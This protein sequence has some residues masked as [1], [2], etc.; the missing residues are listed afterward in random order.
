MKSKIYRYNYND[1]DYYAEGY[2]EDNIRQ[3]M[4]VYLQL[5]KD[6]LS[7]GISPNF[8]KELLLI[9]D[10]K[11]TTHYL[12]LN[13]RQTTS[14]DDLKLYKR[15]QSCLYELS[16]LLKESVDFLEYSYHRYILSNKNDDVVFMNSR[17][18]KD[19]ESQI[20]HIICY[21]YKGS[22]DLNMTNSIYRFKNLADAYKHVRFNLI[23]LGL[24]SMKYKKSELTNLEMCDSFIAGFG[25]ADG[26][27][28]N[29]INDSEVEILCRDEPVLHDLNDFKIKD[30]E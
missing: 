17:Y 2:D 29:K 6:T 24:D 5:D 27:V 21:S 4:E 13:K 23:D 3:S 19:D 11:N 18:I 28:V 7:K 15:K 14:K 30:N 9:W 16:E 22:T 12:T 10:K 20:G 8:E 1:V 26:I 25:S